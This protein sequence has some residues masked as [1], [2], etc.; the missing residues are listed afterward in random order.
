MNICTSISVRKTAR[1]AELAGATDGLAWFQAAR[2]IVD[3]APPGF[4]A[5]DFA[6]VRLATVSWLREGALALCRYA[7]AMRQDV[8]LVAS[9]LSSTVREELEVALEAT[10]QVLIATGSTTESS[11]Q[12][13]VL[14]G[15]LDPALGAALA[16]VEG[17]F[18][19]DATFVSAAIRGLGASAANNRLAALE[20]KGILTSERRGRSRLY[21]PLVENLHYGHRHDRK[22][23]RQ[24]RAKTT[25]MS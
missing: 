15:R 9:G 23:G 19:F 6:G 24:L 12:H 13:P 1:S 4:C 20:A 22:G 3:S 7:A 2:Q 18:E 25:E 17:Q 10:G 5:I 11:F 21:R 8:N 14:L 16:A